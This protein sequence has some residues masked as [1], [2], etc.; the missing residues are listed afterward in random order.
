MNTGGGKKGP[1]SPVSILPEN[2]SDAWKDGKTSALSVATALSNRDGKCL[3]WK[4][5]RDA[6]DWA[7]RA[8]FLKVAAGSGAWPC[9]FPGAVGVHLTVEGIE[10]A[11]GTSTTDGAGTNT[12]GYTPPAGCLVAQ[13]ELQPSQMQDLGDAIPQILEIK[14]KSDKAL[15][16]RV[17]IEFGDESGVPDAEFVKEINEILRGV[18]PGLEF[19]RA[20]GG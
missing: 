17:I 19:N 2:L 20:P 1:V 3:P 15:S 4:T 11:V 18:R 7:L 9:D 8:R 10:P 5:I 6:I 16:F 12:G 14:N 13:S